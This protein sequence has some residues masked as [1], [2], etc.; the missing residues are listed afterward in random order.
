[1]IHSR[2]RAERGT[3]ED[4]EN[5]EG[6]ERKRE[7]WLYIE[8]RNMV[9]IDNEGK[10]LLLEGKINKKGRNKWG[11]LIISAFVYIT[12]VRERERKR[13]KNFIIRGKDRKGEGNGEIQSSTLSSISL[14][15]KRGGKLY[16]YREMLQKR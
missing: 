5:Q 8:N 10:T 15:S 2:P 4:F 11:S 3:S 7:Y 6:R 1:M 13:G 14:V 16:Y 12:G 9:M